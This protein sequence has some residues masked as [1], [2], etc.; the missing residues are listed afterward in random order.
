MKRIAYE[1]IS[2]DCLDCPAAVSAFASG[3]G[4]SAVTET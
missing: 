4:S 3:D 2:T 1:V